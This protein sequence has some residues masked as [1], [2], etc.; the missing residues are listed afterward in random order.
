MNLF[1]KKEFVAQNIHLIPQDELSS[2]H[3]NFVEVLTKNSSTIEGESITLGQVLQ[4]IKGINISGDSV[5]HRRVFNHYQAYKMVEDR[6]VKELPLTEDFMKDVHEI[7]LDGI[8]PGGMYRRVNI[9]VKGS[10]YIPCDYVKL[11]D[12]MAKFFYELENFSGDPVELAAFTHLQIAKIHPFIDGNGRLA[13]LLMNY[14][15]I[16]HGFLPVSISVKQKEEYFNSLEE[17]KVNKNDEPFKKMLNELLNKKYD[18][19]I[20]LINQHLN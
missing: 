16:S 6:A 12:R 4:I 17:F 1:E 5:L 15:L 2:Y 19:F 9:T 14:Q 20:D 13:R 8:T 10:S 18:R 7:L 3:E 11:Y